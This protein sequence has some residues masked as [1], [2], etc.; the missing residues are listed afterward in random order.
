MAIYIGLDIGGT[1]FMVAAGDE[2]GQVL[3]TTRAATPLELDAGLALLHEMIEKVAAGRT[4]AGI[5]AAAGG[6]LDWRQG[7]ISPLHQPQWRSVPLAQIMQDRWHCP[8]HVDVDTNIAALGEYQASEDHPQRFLYLTLS[9]G[10]G[11]GFLVD[12]KI[13]R[14][15]NGEHPEVGH[16]AVNFRCAHPERVSCEC[17]APDCLEALV[18]GNGIRRIYGKPAEELSPAQWDEVAWNLGQGLRNLAAIYAPDVIVLGG[19]IVHGQGEKL[20]G[21]ARLVMQQHLKIVPVPQ[22]RPSC[23]GY[24]TAL[25]G[26]LAAARVGLGD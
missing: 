7:I 21:P 5:G 13:Y 18:S 23:H 19:G 10:M 4:I 8:L 2:K 3:E 9:T 22:V 11:G 12:G 26:A 25:A 17:G 16:Q 15:M 20:L 1:K 14:G 24:N 6:P